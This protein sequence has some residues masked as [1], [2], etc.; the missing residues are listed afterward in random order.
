MNRTELTLLI[1]AIGSLVWA[2]WLNTVG[3]TRF[4]AHP[5]IQMEHECVCPCCG[6][7]VK[8]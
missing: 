3:V 2:A 8:H 7:S 1:L 6:K 5:I 4:H